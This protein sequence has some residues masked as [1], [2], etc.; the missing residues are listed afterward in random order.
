MRTRRQQI[1]TASTRQQGFTLI[2]S[3]VAL[4]VLS[5]GMLGISALFTQGLSSGRTAQYRS[6]AVNLV[7]DLADRIRANRTAQA[8]YAGV[9]ANNNC[10]PLGGGGVDCAPVQMAA[11]DLFVWNQQVQ[12]SLP[13]GQWLIL[14]DPTTLPESYTIQVSWTEVGQGVIQHQMQIQVP[15]V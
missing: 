3:M 6:Q 8:A 1:F 9:A 14:F 15:P 4:V 7:S 12:Q 2:E 11:H 13:T 5:V 10:D